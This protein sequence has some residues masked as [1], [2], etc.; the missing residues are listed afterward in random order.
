MAEDGIAATNATCCHCFSGLG[1]ALPSIELESG[2]RVST[3][4]K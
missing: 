4:I 1:W 3:G 2:R